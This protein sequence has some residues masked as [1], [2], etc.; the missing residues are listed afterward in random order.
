MTAKA[1][2]TA[3]LTAAERRE[4]V[5][6]AAVTEFSAF[7]LHGASTEDIAER[8]G[9]SQPYVFKLFGTKKDLFMAA[10]ERVCDR[11]VAAWARAIE[12]DPSDRL[13]AMGLA[14]AALMIRREELVLLLQG[15]AAGQDDDVLVVNRRRM[16]DM[17][18]YVERASGASA[19]EV[20]AFFAQGMLLT[21]AAGLDLPSLVGED[22]WAEA[23]MGRAAAAL[24]TPA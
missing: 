19:G 23:F 24:G 2:R 11:I 15:F 1:P 13:E 21:V 10:V 3:R 18:R 6:D 17:Y 16:A 7:G 4:V 5:L 20:Q 14:Y 12:P 9:I 22:R 8:A